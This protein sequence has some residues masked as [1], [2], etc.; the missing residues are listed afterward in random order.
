[1]SLHQKK[2]S[3]QTKL[4][5]DISLDIFYRNIKQNC[6]QTDT[7]HRPYMVWGGEQEDIIFWQ[8][9]NLF[10]GANSFGKLHRFCNVQVCC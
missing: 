6:T 8:I 1:L 3:T 2:K 9:R 4:R 10:R 7:M 5:S